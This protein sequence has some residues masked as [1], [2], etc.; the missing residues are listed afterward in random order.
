MKNIIALAL[1]ITSCSPVYVPNLRNSPMF[2]KGGEFQ[3]GVQIGNG[4]EAQSAISV[5]KHIGAIGNFS[6][7]D[8][9][10]VD[11]DGNTSNDKY[12]RHKF[13]EAGIGYFDNDGPMFFEIF[14]GYGKGEGASYNDYIFTSTS[15]KSGKYERYFL[16]PA[17]G[18]NK[19]AMHISFVPRLSAVDFS[20]FSDE[21][22]TIIINQD[23]KFFFEPAFVGRVNMAHN[24]FFFAFQVGASLSMS[25]DLYFNHR[26]FQSSMGFGFRIG[27]SKR[28]EQTQKQE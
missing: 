9:T 25:G 16:Q 28:E 4:I 17:F 21:T 7:I 6:Y 18:L 12:L 13:Y 2:T 19:K 8:R 14:G 5:T 3:A 1:I 23:P 20:E 15:A 11:T 22:T 24:R 27:G 10:S 26:V